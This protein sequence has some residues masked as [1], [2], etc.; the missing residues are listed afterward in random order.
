MADATFGDPVRQTRALVDA[1]CRVLQ[2][3]C[4]SWDA[5]AVAA[6]ARACMR[7]CSGRAML[8]INDHVDV[9]RS[10]GAPAVHLG[11]SDGP[12]AAARARLPPGTLIG[13]ST[14][15][16]A[17]ID[18]AAAEG[19][20]Y[21]GFGP[22]FPTGTKATGFSP[23][24]PDRLAAAVRRFAGP[25]VAIGGIEAANVAAVRAAGAHAWA[26]GG[27]V[28]CAADRAATLGTLVQIDHPTE[29]NGSP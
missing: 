11:Q 26:V 29:G 20:D 21:I 10:V 6:A 22:V 2:L 17:E 12:L 5:A 18:G 14:H 23:Q 8:V 24:G 28:W 9:A 15:D 3:R 25:V 1:G 13:R 16:D 4:K 7:I 27:G 19:A